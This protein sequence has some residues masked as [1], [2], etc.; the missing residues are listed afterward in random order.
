M[1]GGDTVEWIDDQ[2]D[3]FSDIFEFGVCVQ[4]YAGLDGDG[5]GVCTRH[6]RGGRD[7]SGDTGGAVA[8]GYGLAGIV[9][10]SRL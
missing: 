2:H 10:F 9:E 4:D 6:G 3:Q 8:G 7:F 1:P 5:R